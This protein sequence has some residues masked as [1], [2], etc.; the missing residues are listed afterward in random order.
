V[1][2]GN[3]LVQPSTGQA[4]DGVAEA[5]ERD[6]VAAAAVWSAFVRWTPTQ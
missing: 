3:R 1:E 4:V 2:A 6:A 5:S